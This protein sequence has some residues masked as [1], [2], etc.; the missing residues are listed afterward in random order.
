MRFVS[1]GCFF[2][3]VSQGWATDQAESFVGKEPCFRLLPTRNFQQL[4]GSLVLRWV[5]GED[6]A[7]Q[8]DTNVRGFGVGYA[9]IS[10]AGVRQPQRPVWAGRTALPDRCR[11]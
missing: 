2:F 1:W 6:Q 11:K 3:H 5:P 7:Q 8:V 4:M 10:A 9:Q